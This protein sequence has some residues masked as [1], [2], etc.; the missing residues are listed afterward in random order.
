MNFGKNIQSQQDYILCID[1]DN[2]S[3]LQAKEDP[4]TWSS[5][6]ETSCSSSCTT[7]SP[8]NRVVGTPE[9]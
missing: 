2:H 3:K 8:Q 1:V 6:L 9:L 4:A 7:D 5:W